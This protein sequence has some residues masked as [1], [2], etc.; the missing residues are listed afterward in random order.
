MAI[1]LVRLQGLKEPVSHQCIVLIIFSIVT[2]SKVFRLQFQNERLSLLVLE[3]SLITTPIG[4]PSELVISISLAIVLA[5]MLPM[6][7][8]VRP[9]SIEDILSLPYEPDVEL[10]NLSY[11]ALPVLNEMT[12]LIRLLKALTLEALDRNLIY[13]IHFDG[14][15]EK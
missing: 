8:I 2:D 11:A 10:H 7:S 1:T 12:Y 9:V 3:L 15:Q 4:S 13:L 14:S 6:F 5:M